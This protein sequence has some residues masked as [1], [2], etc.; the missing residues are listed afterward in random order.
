MY[1]Y[2]YRQKDDDTTMHY[3]VHFYCMITKKLLHVF[4]L[5]IR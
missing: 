4:S 2:I 5:H 1:V 3:Y